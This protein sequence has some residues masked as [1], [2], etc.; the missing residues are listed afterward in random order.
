MK[1]K[2]AI[3]RRCPDPQ[4]RECVAVHGWGERGAQV[5]V[6]VAPDGHVYRQNHYNRR[7]NFWF[8]LED[9]KGPMKVER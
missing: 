7:E 5:L 9:E 3:W 1:I 4:I 8:V 2:Y 6:V